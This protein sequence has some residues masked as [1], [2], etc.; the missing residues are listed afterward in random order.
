M[1]FLVCFNIWLVLVHYRVW[2]SARQQENKKITNKILTQVFAS[3]KYLFEKN[4]FLLGCCWIGI[5]F[6]VCY[7]WGGNEDYRRRGEVVMVVVE[8]TGDTFCCLGTHKLYITRRVSQI[9]SNNNNKL[10]F[11]FS[12]SFFWVNTIRTTMLTYSGNFDSILG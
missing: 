1:Y 4:F 8:A 3:F 10:S 12:L 7:L 11:L 2:V 5:I 6:A 9:K